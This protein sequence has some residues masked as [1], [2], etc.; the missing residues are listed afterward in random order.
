[1][2]AL[3]FVINLIKAFPNAFIVYQ[4][5]MYQIELSLFHYGYAYTNDYELV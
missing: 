3:K 1:M 5:F 2:N 4:A